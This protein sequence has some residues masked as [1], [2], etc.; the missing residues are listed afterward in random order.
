ME[1]GNEDTTGRTRERGSVMV[2]AALAM[3]A[4]LL[5]A[6][7]AIDV[8]VV[9]SSRTQGQSV[10]DVAALA[11]ASKMIEQSGG[12]SKPKVRTDL[13]E[14]AGKSYAAQNWMV[15]NPSAQVR[16]SSDA[17]QP[18]VDG[19]FTFGEWNF[20][21][22]TLDPAPL[23][24]PN[25]VTAVRVNLL[26]DD[27]VNKRSPTFLSRLLG[28]D[29]FDVKTTSVA[30]LGF[31][32]SFETGAFDLPVAIDSCK[33]TTDAS[34]GECGSDFCA[35]VDPPPNSCALKWHQGTVT[36]LEFASTPQQ[37]ACWTVFDGSS[38]SI[39]NP[40]L[41]EILDNGNQ[42]GLQA[43]DEAYLDNGTKEETLKDIRNMFYGC[44]DGSSQG[45]CISVDS[46][47]NC[48]ARTGT[49]GGSPPSPV[50]RDRYTPNPPHGVSDPL[51]P[52]I[53]SWVVLL[54]VFEC[55]PGRNCS[56]G[57]PMKIMGGVCFEIR[58][59]LAPSGDYADSSAKI[60][61]RFLCPESDDPN[62]VALFNQYCRVSGDTGGCNTGLIATRPVLVK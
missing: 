59:V 60:K 26:M 51:A 12:S 50:G 27:S 2:I 4:L 6:A 35:T 53:D 62:E 25:R 43:G 9:W 14:A 45:C 57:D 36:C 22:R 58:E 24:D 38:P 15:A 8:G 29:G 61:G 44:E 7:L 31:V 5:F 11:A 28:R 21:T 3:T 46:Q 16:E 33:I 34:P 23:D 41:Q 19:D 55:D 54:P 32:G 18:N 37:N 17:T 52:D 56:G 39:N 20:D 48:T 30:Y 42:S 10:S 40:K 47:G 13:A 1:M 49:G